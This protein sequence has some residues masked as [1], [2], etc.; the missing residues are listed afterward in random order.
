MSLCLS[1]SLSVFLC[2]SLSLSVF[3]CLSLSVDLS[4][5]LSL[6]QSFCLSISPSLCLSYT[7]KYSSRNKKKLLKSAEWWHIYR[8]F[9]NIVLFVYLLWLNLALYDVISFVMIYKTTKRNYLKICF[10]FIFVL[11]KL[12]RRTLKLSMESDSEEEH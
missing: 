12:S 10:K 11:R 1:L 2:L 5:S 7:Q 3:I 8:G 9:E 6:C 4:A